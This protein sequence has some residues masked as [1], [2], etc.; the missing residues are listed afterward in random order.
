MY[1]QTPLET[2]YL[3]YK[4]ILFRFESSQLFFSSRML[5]WR[6]ETNTRFLVESVNICKFLNMLCKYISLLHLITKEE[7]QLKNEIHCLTLI[8]LFFL[9]GLTLIIKRKWVDI[10]IKHYIYN[11]IHN[12]KLNWLC[13]SNLFHCPYLKYVKW[14]T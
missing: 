9:T 4:L 7:T 2:H 8:I 6:K 14:L 3:I 13:I 10:Q 5:K 11:I 1:S 12:E